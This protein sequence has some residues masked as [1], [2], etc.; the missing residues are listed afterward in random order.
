M[1]TDSDTRIQNGTADERAAAYRDFFHDQLH[2]DAGR[3]AA[4][5]QALANRDG[6]ELACLL[7]GVINGAEY[8]AERE[9]GAPAPEPVDVDELARQISEM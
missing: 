7:E 9:F 3:A 8:R 5:R 4:L 1:F 2:E 6:A